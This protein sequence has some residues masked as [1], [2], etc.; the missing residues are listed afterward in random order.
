MARVP[1]ARHWK[2][3]ASKISTQLADLYQQAGAAPNERLVVDA[4][5]LDILHDAQVV[6]YNLVKIVEN[7]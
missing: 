3:R 6:I 7:K 4:K 2:R 5:V 1:S